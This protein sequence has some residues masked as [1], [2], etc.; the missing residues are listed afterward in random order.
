MLEVIGAAPGSH[1]DI[2]W[3][4]TWLDSPERTEVRQ[5]LARMK[6]ERPKE[7][8]P[9]APT[10]DKANYSEFAAPFPVQLWE[11]LKR[12]MEQYWRTPSY[13]YSKAVLCVSSVSLHFL[14]SLA[15]RCS[16]NPL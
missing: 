4:Q 15:H 13:I 6:E 14:L 1:T 5:E 2:D 16:T 11:V 9:S 8:H 12:V 10:N 7:A 3:H